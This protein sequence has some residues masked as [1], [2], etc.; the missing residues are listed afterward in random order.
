MIELEHLDIRAVNMGIN[1]SD[2]SD[3]DIKKT[4]ENVFNKVVDCAKDLVPVAEQVSAEYGVPIMNKRFAVT[5]VSYIG[6]SSHANSY[7]P[8]AD[9]MDRAAHR[10]GVD[11]AGGFS[12]FVHKGIQ[13]N[14]RVLMDSIPEALSRTERVCSSVSVASSKAGIN[15]DAVLYMARIIKETAEATAE[16]GGVGCAKLVVFAN[17]TED[18]PFIA[19]ALHGFGEGDCTVNV[20]ISGPGV[21]KGVLS[22][23]KD[24]DL[25][26]VA[27]AIKK[28]AFK[29][30]RMGELVGREVSRR[31]GVSFGIVDLSLAPT[32]EQGDSVAEI[33]EEIGLQR[34]GAPGSTAAL[35]L[36]T[37][38]VKKGGAMASSSV[39]GLSGAFIPLSEDM[40]MVR[41]AEEGALTL[42]KLEA[43]TSVC[44]V[45]LDMITIPGDTPVETIAAIIAD[46]MAIGVVNNKTTGVRIIPVP[47]KVAG[48]RVQYGGLLGESVIMPVSRFSPERFIRRGG[49]IPPPGKYLG[50]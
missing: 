1:I 7:F 21:I 32:P 47:G 15:M 37:D 14:D 28:T 50:N 13:Q 4:A 29:I 10:V 17:V 24:A 39:G 22:R 16:W 26:E 11:Y 38:A 41:S 40:G 44:S 5:P 31:L 27:E 9:A 43:M 6:A 25:G 12:A 19:G 49:R 35:A 3:P 46:E 18:N 30:T 42:E 23:L 20:G 2:C 33:L 36:L 8:I 34:C 45:G 48:D